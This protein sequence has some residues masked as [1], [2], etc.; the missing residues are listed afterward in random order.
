MFQS[1]V[2]RT[3]SGSPRFMSGSPR[4]VLQE[5]PQPGLRALVL[6]GGLAGLVSAAIACNHFEHVTLVE[7]DRIAPADDAE[8]V[9]VFGRRSPPLAAAQSAAAAAAVA[10]HLMSAVEQT[11]CHP[12]AARGAA[13][14]HSPD[15]PPAHA[16][17]WRAPGNRV[18]AARFQGRGGE[19]RVAGWQV[20]DGLQGTGGGN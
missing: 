15:A 17:D 19:G 16:G 2:R 10:T 8:Q 12:A 20:G 13:A 18:G 4:S 1:L 14:W 7:A 9:R 11:A 6:G 5:P 3:I